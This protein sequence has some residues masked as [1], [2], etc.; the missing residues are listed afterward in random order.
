M[1]RRKRRCYGCREAGH[2]RKNCPKT[3]LNS[4]GQPIG[5]DLYD[6]GS[7]IGKCP[8]VEIEIADT[9]IPCLLDTGSMVITISE[10]IYNTHLCNIPI[11]RDELITFVRPM[12]WKS[13]ML[14]T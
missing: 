12:D 14:D 7:L 13:R 11:V 2:I 3:H 5:S 9:V 10:S 4:K 1:K 8:T 6:Y